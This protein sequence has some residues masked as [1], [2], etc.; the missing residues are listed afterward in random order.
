MW[1]GRSGHTVRKRRRMQLRRKK[2]NKLQITRFHDHPLVMTWS[3]TPQSHT[4]PMILVT[5]PII[6]WARTGLFHRF[7]AERCKAPAR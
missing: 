2:T 1:R 5:R 7:L 4:T 3:A 6:F